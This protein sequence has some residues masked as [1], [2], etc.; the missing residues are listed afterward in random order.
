M[1][2]F[3]KPFLKKKKTHN[4]QIDYRTNTPKAFFFKDLLK[5]C[6]ISVGIFYNNFFHEDLLSSAA[7]LKKTPKRNLVKNQE[8]N[9]KQ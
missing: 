3:H 4:E 1:N 6:I 9:K 5:P 8:K 2:S 7:F